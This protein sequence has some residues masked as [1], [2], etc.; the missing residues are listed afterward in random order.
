[1]LTDRELLDLLRQGES[2]RVEFEESPAG[3]S[4]PEAVCAF[5]NDLPGSG[6]PGVIM[7][8]VRDNGEVT[9]LEVTDE[10]LRTL[11]DI[12][13]DGNI[14]PVPS[15]TV[16]QRVLQA[17]EIV[18]VTVEPSDSP[19]VKY[20]GRT[21]VRSGPRRGVATPQ[22]E[23]I[24]IE[25][26]RYRNRPFDI[27]PMHGSTLSD[28]DLNRFQ[29]DYLPR[30]VAPEILAENDRELPQQLAGSKMIVSSDDV[31]AT[32]LGML[33]LGKHPS[34]FLPGAYVLFLRITGTDMA[35]DVVDAEEMRGTVAE[36][37]GRLEDKLRAHNRTAVEFAARP[38]E[39]RSHEYPLSA[40]QQIV[41]NAVMHRTYEESHAPVK[42][43]WFSD[44]IE[45]S[46]PGGVHG[47]V[48]PE[49]LGGGGVTDYRNPNLAEAMRVLGFVQRFGAGIP[50]ARRALK[51]AGHP[52]PEFEVMPTYVIAKVYRRHSTA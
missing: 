19:P 38:V 28:L 16:E 5:A 14:L 50:L 27:Q 22:D 2:H 10:L 49:N 47:A 24:L 12:K 44:R 37:I 23:R 21:L 6:Q 13:T 48:T 3:E 7:I 9:D 51:D 29:T 11:T 36:V 26:R 52:P 45:V 41:R 32:V 4:I 1:M 34:E 40:L 43:V 18:V 46:S 17:R 8:G 39:Q 30:A 15:M 33:V 20:R 31:E 35:D 42:V 25:K